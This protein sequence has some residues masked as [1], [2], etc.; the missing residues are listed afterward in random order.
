MASSPF[1]RIN[2]R[3]A[4]PMWILRAIPQE[5]AVEIVFIGN[6]NRAELD[7]QVDRV[8]RVRWT[9][10]E[11]VRG[12]RAAG[13]VILADSR[14]ETV[15]VRL[16]RVINPM[17]EIRATLVGLLGP[18]LVAHAVDCHTAELLNVR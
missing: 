16:E 11:T 1:D 17:R 13:I 5:D 2:L 6:H 7:A 14:A 12:A 18:E 15:G 9:F 8:A 3:P 10:S 4:S